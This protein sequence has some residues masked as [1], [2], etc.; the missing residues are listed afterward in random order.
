M[1]VT[2]RF[3]RG[4][5]NTTGG[6]FV[7]KLWMGSRRLVAI[8]LDTFAPHPLMVK[9]YECPQRIFLHNQDHMQYA[10]PSGMEAQSPKFTKDFQITYLQIYLLVK[11]GCWADRKSASSEMWIVDRNF[12]YLSQ[13]T[14]FRKCAL[15]RGCFQPVEIKHLTSVFS[16]SIHCTTR[17]LWFRRRR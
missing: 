8:A 17:A 12:Q 15:K 5:P 10:L 9:G 4:R 13:H 7:G 1:I 11:C 6:H 14:N 16:P 2:L 3:S